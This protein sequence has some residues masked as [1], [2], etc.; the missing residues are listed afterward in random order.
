MHYLID[1]PYGR[2]P[3]ACEVALGRLPLVARSEADD[4]LENL[5]KAVRG[6]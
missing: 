1:G 5:E 6:E 2:D 4:D 3:T